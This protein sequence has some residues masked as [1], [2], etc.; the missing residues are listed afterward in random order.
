M[1]NHKFLTVF[2]LIKT[3][4]AFTTP[5]QRSMSRWHNIQSNDVYVK[6][7]KADN[8]R[9]RSAFKLL[10]IDD[11]FKI[12][13][14]KKRVVDLG[15]APGSW[16]QVAV[17]QVSANSSIIPVL[18]VDILD[19]EPVSGAFHLPKTSIEDKVSIDQAMEKIWG[20]GK[21]QLV[22]SDML[23]N[24]SGENS[25]DHVNSV[26]LCSYVLK[27]CFSHLENNGSVVM[28]IYNGPHESKFVKLL[29]AYF[30]KV[31]RFKPDASRKTSKE[32]YLIA[33]RFQRHIFDKKYNRS[34][35]RDDL[36]EEFD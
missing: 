36:S 33:L 25:Y 22:L 35:T 30:K 19:F 2:Q 32:H 10:Q 23:H 1:L 13:K 29:E 8:F 18:S 14:G 17:R 11:S 34:E 12:F 26:K 6:A 4:V 16:S 9:C 24:V 7:A 3:N 15:A 28:K 20:E 31:K 27:F 21:P 5:L